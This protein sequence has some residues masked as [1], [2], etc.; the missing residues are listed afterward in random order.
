MKIKTSSTAPLKY[1]V[2]ITEHERFMLARA[3][4]HACRYAKI[5]EYDKSWSD[6]METM[7]EVLDQYEEDEE[8]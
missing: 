4:C 8:D 1:T 7:Q 5:M 2:E 6:E 3:L